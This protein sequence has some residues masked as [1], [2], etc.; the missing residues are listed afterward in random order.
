MNDQDHD[1]IAR[2]AW[3]IWE[4]EGKPANRSAQHWHQAEAEYF[5]TKDRDA[6]GETTEFLPDASDLSGSTGT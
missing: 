2:I 3:R 5:R 6:A 1:Q 4:E